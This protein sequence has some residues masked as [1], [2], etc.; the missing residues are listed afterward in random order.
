VGFFHPFNDP[1]EVVW[2]DTLG[3]E[4]DDDPSDNCIYLRPVDSFNVLQSPLHVPSDVFLAGTP[5]RANLNVRPPAL[6]KDT[7]VAST[8][9]YPIER[10]AD[11]GSY[12]IAQSRRNGCRCL[13][14]GSPQTN[15]VHANP[16]E[17]RPKP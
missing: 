13:A 2:V 16:S 15:W 17:S 10:G 8:R 14:H 1:E 12:G 11:G 9:I 4:H 5:D 7:P 3:V 6:H